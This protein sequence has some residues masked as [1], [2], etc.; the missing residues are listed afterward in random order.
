MLDKLKSRLFSKNRDAPKDEPNIEENSPPAGEVYETD[1]IDDLL[2]G[3]DSQQIVEVSNVAED[4]GI[5]ISTPQG[6]FPE[7]VDK[8]LIKQKDTINELTQENEEL[9]KK[10]D[11]AVT[12]YKKIKEEFSKM[13]LEVSLMEIPDAST[14][15]Q[16]AML[17]Q[18]DSIT[19]NYD[20]ET[21]QELKD[22]QSQQQQQDKPKVN[23]KLNL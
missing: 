19:G 11:E 20:S 9:S 6:Y 3:D 5:R 22:I 21:V 13:K 4:F 18:M 1:K 14:E 15:T 17:S 16:F 2:N 7:D 12:S 8:I 10:L 23:L